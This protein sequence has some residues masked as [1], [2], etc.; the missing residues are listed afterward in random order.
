MITAVL[1]YFFDL[2]VLAMNGLILGRI[3]TSWV[4][5]QSQIY[6]LLADITE[7][8]L[9]PVRKLLPQTGMLDLAPLVTLLAL[10]LLQQVIHSLIFGLL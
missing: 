6:Q 9:A 8:V 2:F 1:I 5:P 10:N 7:P 3:I 4:A